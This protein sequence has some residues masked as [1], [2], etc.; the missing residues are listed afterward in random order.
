MRP[1]VLY[2][3]DEPANLVAFR[4]VFEDHF[5]IVTAASGP[6]ALA[7]LPDQ[8]IGVLLTDQRM[9]GMSGAELC[10]ETRQ[11]FPEIVRMVVTAYAD[12]HEA[13]ASIN[14]GA[15]SRYVIKPWHEG[16]LRAA[17]VSA[18]EAFEAAAIARAFKSELLAQGAQ[19]TASALLGKVVQEIGDPAT[20]LRDNL[21]WME[22]ALESLAGRSEPEERAVLLR[23]AR[24]ALRDARAATRDLLDRVQE[25]RREAAVEGAARPLRMSEVLRAAL[26]F[27]GSGPGQPLR[28][29]VT[30]EEDFELVVAPGELGQALV[31]FLLNAAGALQAA[32]DAPGARSL[33]VRLRRVG[34]SGLVEL[35][36]PASPV[37]AEAVARLLEPLGGGGARSPSPDGLG[38][39]LARDLVDALGGTLAARPAGDDGAVLSLALPLR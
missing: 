24:A 2:V 37:G 18:L 19:A 8:A 22:Q 34:G 33:L 16:E 32:R 1:A 30:V 29:T 25:L 14:R 3:D 9:P 13:V 12:V 38:L 4:Y 6:E 36:D 15:V 17:L 39:G 5:R 26:A 7:L 35:E 28:F 20:A 11:R 27:I 10:A 23:E 31:V 21:Q